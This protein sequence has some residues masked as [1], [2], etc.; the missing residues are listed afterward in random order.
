MERNGKVSPLSV[1]HCHKTNVVRGLLCNECNS[2]L[3][4]F[5]DNIDVMASAISYL[6]QNNN[7]D[8]LQGPDDN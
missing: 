5:K 8:N 2:G 1:D 7:S 6:Q 4:K 3:G